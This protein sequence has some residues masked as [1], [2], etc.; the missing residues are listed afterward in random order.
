MKPFNTLVKVELAPNKAA[1][2]VDLDLATVVPAG[3]ELVVEFIS[4]SSEMPAGQKPNPVIVVVDKN[5]SA[6]VQHYPVTHFQLT[7]GGSEIHKSAHPV[8]MR[9]P[10]EL[11][12]RT[13][14][15]RDS[16]TGTARCYFGISGYI[17]T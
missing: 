4:T 10:R 1:A 9:L 15:T 5:N 13:D 17:G 12:L 11:T 2:W 14:M 7:Y 16:T 6:V 3:H 8:R